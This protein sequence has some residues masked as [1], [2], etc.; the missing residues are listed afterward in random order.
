MRRK[1]K[2]KTRELDSQDGF[3]SGEE[4][5][6]QTKG[7]EERPHVIGEE[8]ELREELGS[9]PLGPLAGEGLGSNDRRRLGNPN[10]FRF[11]VGAVLEGDDNL[12]GRGLHGWVFLW[13]IE[14]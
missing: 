14:R 5:P 7:I 12:G 10:G 3:G 1:E 9:F 4:S 6:L 2:E 11:A 8:V 13:L